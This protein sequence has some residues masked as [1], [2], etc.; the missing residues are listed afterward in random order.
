MRALATALLFALAASCGAA[1]PPACPLGRTAA[2][3]CPGGVQ[4][5]QEC[6]PLGV[7]GVCVCPGADAGAD[8]ADA[9]AG[10][11]AGAT[12]VASDADASADVAA[13]DVGADAADATADATP[14][15]DAPPSAT[16]HAETMQVWESIN[17]GPFVRAPAWNCSLTTANAV[18]IRALVGSV[19]ISPSGTTSGS[20]PQCP[21]AIFAD[22][23]AS[24]PTLYR[25][26]DGR[27]RANASA[28]G[29]VSPPST[30]RDSAEVV[31]RFELRAFGCPTSP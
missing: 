5:A 15:S 12:D 18:V 3:A 28:G 31:A 7:W 1:E 4:G 26:S 9:D 22:V 27:L 6:G 16:D 24:A 23:T 20:T 11:D 8:I 30:C 17:G 10:A 25:S 21:G 14:A 29:S 13:V 19:S 2:C